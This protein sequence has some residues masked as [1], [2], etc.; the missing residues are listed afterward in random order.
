[1]KNQKKGLLRQSMWIMLAITLAVC[2]SLLS[3]L[4]LS[5]R[6]ARSSA[7][8]VLSKSHEQ[9][10]E[11][12]TT[13]LNTLENAAFS[14]AYAPVT[15]K[16]LSNST[17]GQRL[18]PYAAEVRSIFS[19]AFAFYSDL[20]GISL[21]D[22][23][24][25]YL[26]STG[27]TLLGTNP[28]DQDYESITRG[29]YSSTQAD[30][31]GKGSQFM[32]VYPVFKNN[33]SEMLVGA[34]IG[35][36]V[37]SLHANLLKRMME[38]SEFYAGTLIYLTDASGRVMVS[39]IPWDEMAVEANDETKG[40][41]IRYHTD[42]S[43]TG[44][45]LYSTMPSS[46]ISDDMHP[47]IMLVY[48]AGVVF[49]HLLV[50]V[51]YF[52]RHY[53]L[54]PISTLQA[55]MQRI[56]E[57]HDRLQL[58]S[59]SHNEL[60]TIMLLMNEMLDSLETQSNELLA[61]K[62]QVLKEETARQQMEI[63]AYRNQINPHFLYNTLDCIRGIAF[64]HHAPEIVE[65]SEALSKMFRYAVHGSDLATV[66]DEIKYVND[67]AT[68]I[69]HRFSNRITIRM[70][71]SEDVLQCVIIKMLLQPLVENAV[72]HGLERKKGPGIVTIK[73]QMTSS[74]LLFQVSDDGC[75]ISEQKLSQVN[76]QIAAVQNNTDEFLPAQSSIGLL[77]IARRLFLHYGREATFVIMQQEQSG[78]IVEIRTPIRNE[79]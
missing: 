62:T 77:N 55:F 36:V 17:P 25:T 56:P 30:A 13:S 54:S 43:N 63:I 58:H 65:I 19:G 20:A 71:V 44:W 10:V 2:V 9:I 32:L 14:V 70:E 15:Q 72:L 53:I 21:Y 27:Y 7:Q 22:A 52:F 59:G 24:R 61:S 34:K 37:F 6:I 73:I 5:Y 41:N 12:M 67:Y 51:F 16:L 74:C 39:N 47:M 42:I 48:A 68:I 28:L 78:T 57:T 50:W 38:Q 35:Y 76:Q 79:W 18:L 64:M 33:E 26:I 3:M 66:Q 69:G 8:Q 46:S 45:V 11:Q 75:G 49:L 1:M 31:L 40:A 60:D 29:T 23:E 4:A